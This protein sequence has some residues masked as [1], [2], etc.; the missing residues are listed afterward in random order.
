MNTAFSQNLCCTVLSDPHQ[1]SCSFFTGSHHFVAPASQVGPQTFE[2][3]LD[4]SLGT[5]H[6]NE[7]QVCHTCIYH[8][9]LNSLEG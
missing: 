7:K 6:L 9:T 8:T 5:F 4:A 3:P 1:S 2:C